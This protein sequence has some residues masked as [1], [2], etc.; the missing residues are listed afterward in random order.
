MEQDNKRL[1]TQEKVIKILEQLN[2]VS[3]EN[4]SIAIQSKNSK[5]LNEKS[6][7]IFNIINSL[8]VGEL[9]EIKT[10]IYTHFNINEDALAADNNSGA[11]KEEASNLL[12][13][14][15]L[16]KADTAKKIAAIQAI[17]AIT[18]SSLPEAKGLYDQCVAGTKVTLLTGLKKDDPKINDI[19]TSFA[20]G[21]GEI[22]LVE[23]K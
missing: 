22:S 18:G 12:Y 4:L 19:K 6:L 1:L 11:N 15:L 5:D 14:V 8:N 20:N 21:L 17:K 10:G 7:E 3:I 13:D 23:K 9:E 16:V 2:H